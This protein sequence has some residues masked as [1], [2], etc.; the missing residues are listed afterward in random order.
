MN[1]DK[2]GKLYVVGI[3]P[4]GVEYLTPAA[5]SAIESADT[6]VGYKTYL[7]LITPFLQGKDVVSSGMRQ[8]VDR[9]RKAIAFA[10][11]GRTVA[12]VSGGDAG[13]YG[14][15]GLT[16]ELAGADGPEV[17]I[18]PAVSAVQAAAARLGA[19]LMHD[20]AVISL[21]DLLTPWPLIR[22]RL[23]AAAS[24][25]FV[26]ALYNPRSKGRPGHL[27]A[28]RQIILRHRAAAN[29]VGIVR[30]ATRADETVETG[31]L[32][33]FSVAGVDM[34]SL[35]IIGNS[36][37]RIDPGGRMVTPRGYEKKHEVPAVKRAGA[38][39]Q[40][41]SGE[42]ARSLFIGGTGS[43]VGKSVLTAG[44]CRLLNDRGVNVAPFK[45]QNMALN[46]AVT[47][48]GGEIGRAQALQ[49]AA[50][51]LEPH[52]DM[53]PILLK[54]NSDTGSQV[55]V[56]GRST[57]NRTVAEYHAGK[58]ELFSEVEAAY[59]RLA[60]RHDVVI[61]EGAGSIAEINLK[62]HDITNLKAAEM[63]DAPVLLV[64]DIDRGGVFAALLGTIELLAPAEKS[65]VKGLV[66]NRFRGDATLLTDGL[67]QIEDRTGIPVVGVVPWLKIDLPEEDSVALSRKSASHK[68]GCL[69][70]GVI[71]LPRISNYTDFDTLA[72][73][74]DICLDYL[75]DPTTVSDCDLLILPGTKNTLSDML[76]LVESGFAEAVREFHA[77]GKRVAGICGG[78]QMLGRTLS[79]PDGVES[80]IPETSGLGLLD[81]KTRMMPDKQT[82][83]VTAE[84]FETAL[85]HGFSG[86]G[87]LSGY[88]IHMGDTTCGPLARPLV[89]LRSRSGSPVDLADGAISPDGRVWGT[90]LHGLFD[91]PELRRVLID[92]L[93]HD[94]GQVRKA[95][96]LQLSLENELDRLAAHLEEHLDLQKIFALIGFAG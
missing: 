81:I 2:T 47:P 83:R 25:D 55:V 63:A 37:T 6:V 12:L 10:A 17:E 43:D 19:P 18:V 70:I 39:R 93:W 59:R 52:V 23:E 27:D 8:E 73:E 42:M 96:P 24:A 71:R 62:A 15:A 29:P 61:L 87:Q 3:G 58:K 69:Q 9:C 21:S 40:S 20:F 7:E 35:V 14:M 94:R 44:L 11:A 76:W 88:E 79:D 92:Q 78:L 50:S 33:S 67:R 60:S 90:Y 57:G 4:G 51:R 1:S 74:K 13:V 22:Q 38:D 77:N 5:A 53:N 56:L 28:A 64:A 31:E 85:A 66:I 46:S 91:N 54:P 41:A 72:S 45:A 75:E 36:Q 95:A 86:V 48:A 49:A 68:E 80:D 32:A 34:F 89:R 65:R 82:H 16:L 26:I 30:H 84:F